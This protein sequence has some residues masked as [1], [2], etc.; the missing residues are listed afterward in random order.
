[1]GKN[2]DKTLILFLCGFGVGM[3]VGNIQLPSDLADLDS[4]AGVAIVATTEIWL[5]IHYIVALTTLPVLAIKFLKDR[6][7]PPL[8]GLPFAFNAGFLST[9]ILMG[10]IHVLTQ[11]VTT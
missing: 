6:V 7:K 11:I 2:V 5:V 1:M 10:L 3:F 9:S 8:R 4:E